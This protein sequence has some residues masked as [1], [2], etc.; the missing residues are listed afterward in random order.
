MFEALKYNQSII[1]IN[2][3]RVNLYNDSKNPMGLKCRTLEDTVNT[4][5]KI[6]KNEKYITSLLKIYEKKFT[7]AFIKY[8]ISNSI[9]SL[10]FVYKDI[11]RKKTSI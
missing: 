5:K 3:P 9:A 8:N 4:I 6:V 7:S 10:K 11:D 1:H 2:N